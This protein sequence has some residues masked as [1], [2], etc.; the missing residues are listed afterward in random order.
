MIPRR[1]V[2][3]AFLMMAAPTRPVLRIEV[4]DSSRREAVL[5]FPEGGVFV[6]PAHRARL[7]AVYP[8]RTMLV[9][10]VS[11]AA[12]PVIGTQDILA[13]VGPDACLLALETLY[14]HGADGDELS[15]RPAMMPDHR[16]IQLERSAAREQ[17]RW[18]RET[19][20]D[21]LVESE[22]GLHDAPPR[23]VLAGTW[24]EA[25]SHQRSAMAAALPPKCREIT[26]DILAMCRRI[27]LF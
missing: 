7:V 24:Q 3:A 1:A 20:T 6:C 27:T 26:P 23:P 5:S 17:D 13:L 11:F 12:D 16:H 15:T 19:W 18:R 21:Y 4:G 10:A 8:L 2:L 14:F 25:L 22:S 9:T